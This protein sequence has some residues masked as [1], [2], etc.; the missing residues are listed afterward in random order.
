MRDVYVMQNLVYQARLG[1]LDLPVREGLC[2]D[3]NV[4]AEGPLIFNVKLGSYLYNRLFDCCG[5]WGGKDAVVIVYNKDEF[6]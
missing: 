4:V 2:A 6:T 1:N 3:A 5:Y